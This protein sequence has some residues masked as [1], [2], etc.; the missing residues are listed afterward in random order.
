VGIR[1]P[2][3]LS[4]LLIGLTLLGGGWLVWNWLDDR[5]V[6]FADTVADPA[7]GPRGGNP[8]ARGRAARPMQEGV[9]VLPGRLF[10]IVSGPNRLEARFNDAWNLRYTPPGGA[11][12]DADTRRVLRRRSA[13]LNNPSRAAQ[14]SVTDEQLARLRA[15]P[16]AMPTVDEATRQHVIS[17]IERLE[18]LDSDSP[19]AMTLKAEL[20]SQAASLGTRDFQPHRQANLERARQVRAILTEDQLAGDDRDRP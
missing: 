11:L 16:E 19:E 13:L 20:T 6:P 14:L 9:N 12:M 17:L 7:A 15:I 8:F 3:W 2:A 18:P 5:T 4:A 1:S 10:V